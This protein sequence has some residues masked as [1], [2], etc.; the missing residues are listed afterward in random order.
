MNGET[1][2][3]LSHQLQVGTEEEAFLIQSIF[4]TTIDCVQVTISNKQKDLAYPVNIGYTLFNILFCA[5][6]TEKA[7]HVF[8]WRQWQA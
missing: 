8:G 4:F 1:L 2:N 6:G 5:E 7:V 3:L